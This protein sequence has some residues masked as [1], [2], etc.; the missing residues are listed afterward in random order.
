MSAASVERLIDTILVT[1]IALTF[2]LGSI[3][4]PDGIQSGVLWLYASHVIAILL[5]SH[6][7]GGNFSPKNLERIGTTRPNDEHG[8]QEKSQRTIKPILPSITGKK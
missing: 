6:F 3:G 8:R 5:I 2:I 4:I 7:L 1:L